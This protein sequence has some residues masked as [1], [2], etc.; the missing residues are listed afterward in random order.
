MSPFASAWYS[1]VAARRHF[2]QEHLLVM[3]LGLY[4][5]PSNRSNRDLGLDAIDNF[6]FLFDI[7]RVLYCERLKQNYDWVYLLPGVSPPR[8]GGGVRNST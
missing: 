7:H 3:V 1:S 4:L 5:G 2:L 6:S 8:R